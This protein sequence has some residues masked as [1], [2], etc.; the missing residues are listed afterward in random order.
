VVKGC[1][2][3]KAGNILE[4]TTAKQVGKNFKAGEHY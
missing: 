2:P 3:G 1:V 4:L